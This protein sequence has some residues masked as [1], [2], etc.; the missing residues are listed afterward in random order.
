MSENRSR[1][2][3]L[4]FNKTE[5][6]KFL[7]ASKKGSVFS[8]TVDVGF[9]E[10]YLVLADNPQLKEFIRSE[11]L[12]VHNV[13]ASYGKAYETDIVTV[14]LEGNSKN[15]DTEALYTDFTYQNSVGRLN[16]K[17][18]RIFKTDKG[19][20][21]IDEKFLKVIDFQHKPNERFKFYTDNLLRK[22][23]IKTHQGEFIALVLGISSTDKDR[24]IYNQ[25]QKWEL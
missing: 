15:C 1:I 21:V 8:Y 4:A 22:L 9:C 3:N 7:K 14:A 10:G 2:F 5:L 20:F 23:I 25:I 24:E 18:Y 12:N 6:N 11:F 16:K 19:N 17:I 13:W